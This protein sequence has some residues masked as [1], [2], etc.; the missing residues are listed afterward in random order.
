M[1]SRPFL[2]LLALFV[3]AYTVG[4][5]LSGQTP[6]SAP[7]APD[8][9]DSPV[10]LESGASGDPAEAGRESSGGEDENEE[11]ERPGEIG[12]PNR[13][14]IGPPPTGTRFAVDFNPDLPTPPE[15]PLDH[16]GFAD[17]VH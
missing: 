3:P 17:A 6:T 15:A 2:L 4:F 14:L 8:S 9:G 5:R 1:R 7:R 16:P 13:W 10:S 12:A 11:W